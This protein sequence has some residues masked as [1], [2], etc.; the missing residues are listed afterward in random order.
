MHDIRKVNTTG[1][2][3]PILLLI[4]VGVRCKGPHCYLAASRIYPRGIE[5]GMH[6]RKKDGSSRGRV[7][8]GGRPCY[9]RRYESGLCTLG[10]Y[11]SKHSR[12]DH[13]LKL[14][15]RDGTQITAL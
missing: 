14:L 1:V 12:D 13:L 8:V 2:T 3:V 4:D 10:S 7:S 5:E 9:V 15:C 6:V 11:G